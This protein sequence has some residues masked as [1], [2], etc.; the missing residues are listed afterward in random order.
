M[1]IGNYGNDHRNI[2]ASYLIAK[3]S[4]VFSLIN[5]L[6]EEEQVAID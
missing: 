5:K 6:L 2:R 4:P 3:P 1:K